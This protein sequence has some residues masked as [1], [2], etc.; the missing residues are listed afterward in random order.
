MTEQPSSEPRTAADVYDTR[1]LTDD[2]RSLADDIASGMGYGHEDGCAVW[3]EEPDGCS[4]PL[5]QAVADGLNGARVVEV[6]QEWG[7]DPVTRRGDRLHRQTFRPHPLS[8]EVAA[9]PA[10]WPE[11]RP[12]YDRI[13][14]A[15]P[16]FATVEQA[17]E[18]IIEE[19]RRD[20][21]PAA[22]PAAQPAPLTREAL[23]V[24]LQSQT[25]ARAVAVNDGRW[26]WWADGPYAFADAILAALPPAVPEPALD[27]ERLARAMYDA[28]PNFVGLGFG[29]KVEWDDLT[30]QTRGQ[31]VTDAADIAIRYERGTATRTPAEQRAR[32]WTTAAMDAEEGHL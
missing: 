10:P 5:L 30:D 7:Y 32:P 4:C 18:W 29:P 31:L 17:I 19:G 15:V 27:V 20:L 22:Q 21:R 14:A 26:E 9:Q 12:D 24:A 8:A 23:A 3:W 1:A 6:V 2:Q 16:T 13:A 25:L 11:T 28:D